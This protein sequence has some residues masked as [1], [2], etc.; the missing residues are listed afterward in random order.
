M[1]AE[2]S[3]FYCPE[4]NLAFLCRSLEQDIYNAEENGEPTESLHAMLEDARTDHE[5]IVA[6]KL[7]VQHCICKTT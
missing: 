5:T 3:S 7:C 6:E 4:K 1:T 2:N